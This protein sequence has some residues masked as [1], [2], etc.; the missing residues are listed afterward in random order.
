MNVCVWCLCV[1]C[2]CGV[3]VC[4]CVCA[5]QQITYNQQFL[6]TSFQRRGQ[7]CSPWASHKGWALWVGQF[8]GAPCH[9]ST[10]TDRETVISKITA[11]AACTFRLKHNHAP[12][13]SQVTRTD[14][15]F[16]LTNSSYSNLV[17]KQETFEAFSLGKHYTEQI[18]YARLLPCISW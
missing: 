17:T 5:C 1:V 3:C 16:K 13:T 18:I 6:H 12:Q 15:S 8:T 10:D 11:H 2:V 14:G 9:P 4:V 7:H